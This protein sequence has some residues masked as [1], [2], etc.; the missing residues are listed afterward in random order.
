MPV[1]LKLAVTGLDTTPIVSVQGEIDVA[2]APQLRDEL[3][4]LDASGH[5]SVIVDLE[6][7]GFMDSTGLGVLVSGLKR[8]RAGGGELSVVCSRAPLLKVFNLT[9]LSDLLTI[10]PSVESAMA[11]F[12]P[13]SEG[14]QT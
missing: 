13:G 1:E 2:T 3:L 5:S 6:E 4:I 10:Y 7:V 12:E 14:D 11:A 8:S 9:G